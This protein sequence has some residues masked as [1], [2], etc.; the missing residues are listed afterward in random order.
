MANRREF[1]KGSAIV[2]GG[3]LLTAIVERERR[4]DP[5]FRV[6]LDSDNTEVSFEEASQLAHRFDRLADQ[7]DRNGG[8]DPLLT[9]DDLALWAVEVIPMF[10]YEGAVDRAVY[11]SDVGFVIFEDGRRHTQVLGI[12]DCDEYAYLNFRVINPHSSWY[13]IDDA[14]PAI[15]HELAHVQQ[16]NVCDTAGVELIENSAQVVT[17]E[18]L[19]AL[20][21]SGNKEACFALVG[22]MRGTSL[23]IAMS[24]DS[25]T[26]FIRYANLRRQLDHG[27]VGDARLDRLLRRY[28]S[29]RNGVGEIL[30]RYNEHPM[31]MMIRG[32]RENNGRVPGL[33]INKRF[34]ESSCSWRQV[35]EVVDF[36]I[37]DFL[38]FMGHAEEMVS[39]YLRNG[40]K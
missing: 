14:I 33:A 5:V 23:S 32:Y 18:I 39:H 24:Q 36:P 11:P 40:G 1:L 12:S 6:E 25:G 38:Y 16:G 15:V 35:P 9:R 21:N 13:R 10:E 20:A 19:A 30:R 8:Y 17:W 28:R 22:A 4:I 27:G 34:I 26:G 37:D 7:I 3:A 2:A 29:D 31:S